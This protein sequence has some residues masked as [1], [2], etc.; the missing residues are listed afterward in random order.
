MRRIHLLLVQS[1]YEHLSV[2]VSLAAI[3]ILGPSLLFVLLRESCILVNSTMSHVLRDF[4]LLDLMMV[5]DVCEF[6]DINRITILFLNNFSLSEPFTDCFHA[7]LA[8]LLP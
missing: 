3:N 2:V 5:F 7:S 8:L 4:L 1:T 6:R